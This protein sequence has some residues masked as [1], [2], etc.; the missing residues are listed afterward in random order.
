MISFIIPAYNEERL[1]A[2]T[3]PILHAAA[4]AAGET[5]EVIVVNDASSDQTALIAQREGARVVPVEHR[6]IAA[7]RNS[8]A[9]EAKG[10]IFIFVDADTF[11]NE[12]VIRGAVQALRSG[13]AGGG[14]AVRFD[15]PVP[16]YARVFLPLILSV[17][18]TAK[19]ASGC[20]LFCTRSAFEASGGF[21]ETMFGA[22]EIAMSRA[23]KRQGRVVILKDAVV[24][25]GRKLRAYSGWELLRT[26]F[27]LAMRGRN[28]VRSRKG[29]EMWYEERPDDLI[30]PEIRNDL[31]QRTP[32][33]QIK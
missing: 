19:F 32:S 31:P 29:L 24:T 28:S 10:D 14:S 3:L 9:K 16:A 6:H 15:E 11:V 33:S 1:L 27:K 21:D 26:S 4:Q 7:T 25:S 13:A 22:E 17:F 30:S 5:Y 23:L 18:R 20:F 2:A 12:P 8:G